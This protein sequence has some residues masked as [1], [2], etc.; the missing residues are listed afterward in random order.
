M[1]LMDIFSGD[2]AREAAEAK[3]TGYRVGYS[4]LSDLFGKGRAA[5]TDN[6]GK[7]ASYY[8]PIYDTATKGY[9]AFADALGLGGAEGNTRAKAGFMNNPGYQVT[10][11]AALDN[12]DRHAS[13]RGNLA[14]AS[15]DAI[16]LSG[17]VASQGWS[18]YL[19]ALGGFGGQALGAAGGLGGIYAGLGSGLDANYRGQGGAGYNSAVGVGNADAEGK[20]ADYQASQ[21]TWNAIFNAANLAASVY[22]YGTG[23]KKS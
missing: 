21:N 17:D 14:G 18:S 22:G 5:L 4:D 7:A 12:L 15:A 13:A 9:S 3:A 20:M 6:M 8:A 10:M 23:S 11:D 1:G 19:N 2:K 16:K